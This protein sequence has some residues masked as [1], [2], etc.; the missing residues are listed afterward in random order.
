MKTEK[1]ALGE[2]AWLHMSP[3]MAVTKSRTSMGNCFQKQ[4]RSKEDVVLDVIV[5]NRPQILYSTVCTAV[6]TL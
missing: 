3:V 4:T 5:Q 1:R 6:K 2:T